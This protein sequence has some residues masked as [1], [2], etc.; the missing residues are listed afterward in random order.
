MSVSSML[1]YITLVP[2]T[3]GPLPI[4]NNAMLLRCFSLYPETSIESLFVFCWVKSAPVRLEL[5][6]HSDTR[7]RYTEY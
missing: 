6:T 4:D 7:K 1:L 3:S 5:L 2:R